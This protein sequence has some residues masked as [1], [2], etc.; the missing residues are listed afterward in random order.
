MDLEG[1]R[2]F[3]SAS[4]YCRKTFKQAPLR[5]LQIEGISPAHFR[6]T[7]PHLGASLPPNP[8]TTLPTFE[9]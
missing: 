7:N 6:M 2:K 8:N 1:P 5:L 4:P 3:H 9:D